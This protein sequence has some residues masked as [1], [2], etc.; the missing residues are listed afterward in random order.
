MA[1]LTP[2]RST[3]R[4]SRTDSEF[5]LILQKFIPT[6]QPT[7]VDEPPD[8]GDWLHEIKYDGNRTQLAIA[9]GEV[10]AYTRNGHDW[11]EKYSRIVA[12]GASIDCRSAPIDG[13]VFVQNGHGVTD[14]GALRSAMTKT[15][16]RLIFFA[17]DLWSAVRS[18]V[19]RRVVEGN[20]TGGAPICFHPANRGSHHG[21]LR[22]D[23]RRA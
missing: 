15:P 6:M 10:R 16:E 12:G 20:A 2:A 17:F 13:E 7:M 4:R 22:C 21:R 8:G 9:G 18:Q 19:S 11:T 23:T 5:T 14:F 1:A 3:K